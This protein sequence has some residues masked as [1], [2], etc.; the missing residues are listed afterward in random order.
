V[1]PTPPLVRFVARKGGPP[2]KPP[3]RSGTADP[4]DGG[5]TFAMSQR[6]P[7]TLPDFEV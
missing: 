5:K 2:P 6:P 1:K 3:A 7:F 4:R